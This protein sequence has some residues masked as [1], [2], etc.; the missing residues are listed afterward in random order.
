MGLRRDGDAER[1][2]HLAR[3]LLEL[4]ERMLDW[5]GHV[6]NIYVPTG[7]AAARDALSRLLD[8]EIAAI[9]R[10]IDDLVA[11]VDRLPEVAGTPD[12]LPIRMVL[13][14]AAN[15]T[16]LARYRAEVAEINNGRANGLIDESD[17]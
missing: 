11:H 9:D 14:S 15:E 1:I 17:W 13:T 4:L 7:L 8:D 5:T 16:L 3:R 10:F 2:R 12:L 6:R